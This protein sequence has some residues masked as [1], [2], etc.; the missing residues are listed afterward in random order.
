MSQPTA[1]MLSA[2]Q[3]AAD[4]PRCNAEQLENHII[5]GADLDGAQALIKR[6]LREVLIQENGHQPPFSYTVTAK[7]LRAIGRA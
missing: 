7:G 3:Y 4:H 5:E 6:C 1:G 2:V